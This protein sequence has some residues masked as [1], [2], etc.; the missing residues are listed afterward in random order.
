[1]ESCANVCVLC[2]GF[3]SSSNLPEVVE[4]EDEVVVVGAAVVGAGTAH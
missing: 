2:V 1:M 3:K 4:A